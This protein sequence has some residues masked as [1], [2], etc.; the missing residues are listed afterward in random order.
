MY[1][2]FQHKE[3]LK[4]LGNERLNKR[5]H[6]KIIESDLNPSL[7]KAEDEKLIDLLFVPQKDYDF[8]KEKQSEARLRGQ[9]LTNVVFT[10]ENTPGL[11][12]PIMIGEDGKAIAVYTSSDASTDEKICIARGGFSGVYVGIDLETGEQ[13]AVKRQVML[14][15]TDNYEDRMSEIIQENANLRQQGN[16]IEHAEF[17]DDEKTITYSAQKLLWGKS[18]FKF[19]NEEKGNIESFTI[20]DEVDLCLSVVEA[21]KNLNDMGILHRDIKSDQMLW[22]D[23]DKKAS[24]TD[25]GLGISAVDANN[26]KELVG[27]YPAVPP[28]LWERVTKIKNRYYMM[29]ENGC[30]YGEETEVYGT[31]T[32]LLDILSTLTPAQISDKFYSQNYKD[33]YYDELQGIVAADKKSKEQ[34][35]NRYRNIH[36]EMFNTQDP[37]PIRDLMIRLTDN[38]LNPDRNMRPSF[39][40]ALNCLKVCRQEAK[41]RAESPNP[42]EYQLSQAFKEMSSKYQRVAQLDHLTKENDMPE[43]SMASQ[44]QIFVRELQLA[45]RKAGLPEF[46]EEFSNDSQSTFEETLSK[47]KEYHNRLEPKENQELLQNIFWKQVEAVGT[48]IIEDAPDNKSNVYFIFPRSKLKESTENPG[49]KRDLYLQGD[50]HGYG[51]TVKDAQL[52]EQ[53]SGT[54]IMFRCDSMPRGALVTYYYVQLEPSNGDKSATHFYGDIAYQPP[55]FFPV[56]PEKPPEDKPASKSKEE[57]DAV[58]N[59]FWGEDSVLVDMC[60]KFHKSYDPNSGLFYADSQKSV[61]DLDLPV[62]IKGDNTFFDSFFASKVKSAS[63]ALAS[64]NDKIVDF[65]EDKA[66]LDKCSR[67]ILVFAPEDKK[68]IDNVVIIHDGRF[69]QLGNT[70]ERLEKLYGANTAVIYINPEIGVMQE[71][72][73]NGVQFDAVDSL[74]GMKERMIDLRHRIDNYARFIHEE[75]LPEL[76][77]HGFEIPDDPNKRILVG[78]SAAGTASM[79]MGMKYPHWFGKV[80]VQSPS[81]ANRDRL[82]EF[83]NKSQMPPPPDIYLSCGQFECPEHARNL[84]LPFAKELE[85]HLKIK[86][87][88]NPYGHQMEGWST[89]LEMAL[90]ALGVIAAPLIEE[91]NIPAISIAT[92]S[93][94]GSITTKAEGVTSQVDPQKVTDQTI[95]EAASLSKPVFAYI[96]LKMAER[97]EINLDTPLIDILEDKFGKGDPNAQFGPPFPGIRDHDNYRKLTA[98]MLLSHQAGLPNEF[99]P[100]DF[101]F[102]ANA[103]ESFDYSGEA[104][105]FLMEVVDKVSSPKTV[106]DLAQEEFKTIG[107]DHSSFVRPDTNDLAIGH[108]E[109]G[110]VDERQHFFGIHPAGSLHTT[111]EDYGKFLRACTNDEFI[112]KEM[113]APCIANLAGKDNKGIKQ[114]VPERVLS[115]IG[116]G[117]GIGLQK[118]PDGSTTAFHWGDG[119]GTCRNFAAI[120][121]STNQAVACLTNSANG[122]SVFRDVCEPIV[123]DISAVSEWLSLRE[124]LPMIP[125][126]P[127]KPEADL[128]LVG[129]DEIDALLDLQPSLILPGFSQASAS[130]SRKPPSPFDQQRADLEKP[131]AIEHMP[132]IPD[133]AV[134][135]QDVVISGD[136]VDSRACFVGDDISEPENTLFKVASVTKTMTSALVFKLQELGVINLNDPI[137]KYLNYKDG[138][139]EEVGEFPSIEG[140]TI[141]D[142]LFQTSG[143]RDYVENFD[144][145]NASSNISRAE[146]LKHTPKEKFPDN[147]HHYSNTNYVL[148]GCILEKLNSQI[149]EKDPSYQGNNVADMFRKYIFEPCNMGNSYLDTENGDRAKIPWER[150][151]AGLIVDS[152]AEAVQSAATIPNFEA[153]GVVGTMEDLARFWQGLFN[154]KIIS[155]ESRL[156]M[157]QSRPTGKLDEHGYV[158]YGAGIN[159]GRTTDG[160]QHYFHPGGL[161]AQGTMAGYL[162][163]ENG[164]KA[165]AGIQ[166]FT[167]EKDALIAQKHGKEPPKPKPDESGLSHKEKVQALYSKAGIEEPKVKSQKTL[168]M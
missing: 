92:V 100:P 67:S 70:Q 41:A 132:P 121:L 146:A 122:P 97:G 108:H 23:Q 49:K 167:A 152:G 138:V 153:G 37:D 160:R 133:M 56:T 64:K 6:H 127:I 137:T 147:K 76:V 35:I 9:N 165:F 117:L 164:G 94:T 161:P 105:R 59:L 90:P 131:N 102:V 12:W 10:P 14:K 129:N 99:S 130:K 134:D 13:C 107:M 156:Q 98:R 141:E 39:V 89:D 21:M 135:A 1:K 44:T 43:F 75:L 17:S 150:V 69:Y 60:C 111:A 148:L 79:Y 7:I 5:I 63:L 86:L 47:Y 78:S 30:D 123:G 168:H 36:Q 18:L 52:L 159:I 119:S 38:M 149:K 22:D 4:M 3:I 155:E 154:G 109:D 124:Q 88:I 29:T 162:P 151:H 96:V 143:L 145:I 115:Q 31:A 61:A 65:P 27:N 58:S 80:V 25:L 166:T 28:E 34:F 112:R 113:F 104:Y 26:L 8:I 77:K 110:K 128:S 71:A 118:N 62:R 32:I 50:F 53:L 157:T 126:T 114:E 46:W 87:H 66:D 73:E 24:I 116:W 144:D 19:L 54:D 42:S 57:L 11:T 101:K 81:I 45:I 84:G 103:G 68:A 163:T 158:Y 85:E 55:A 140:I 72:E 139:L 142:L 40:E 83:V 136:V 15:E 51:S 33:D 95:C 106:E 74:P 16:Y 91:N 20:E 93:S 48:P 120:N 2:I 125:K 82:E